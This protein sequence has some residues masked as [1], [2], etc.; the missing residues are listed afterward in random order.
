M[1]TAITALL[2]G[3]E[4]RSQF[5][6][7]RRVRTMNFTL[8][9][10]TLKL[11]KLELRR[12]VIKLLSEITIFRLLRHAVAVNYK[13]S[14]GTVLSVLFTSLQFTEGHVLLFISI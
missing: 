1:Q 12:E 5:S 2:A 13:N 10:F 11:F 4:S 7:D 9:K 3:R 14:S 6:S 8:P